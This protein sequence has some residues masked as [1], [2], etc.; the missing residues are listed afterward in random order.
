MKRRTA[1]DRISATTIGW[2]LALLP[3]LI[4]LFFDRGTITIFEPDKLALF[5]TLVL[6][7]IGWQSSLFVLRLQ[8]GPQRWPLALPAQVLLGVAV[9]ATLCSIAPRWSV[10]GSYERGQG[11]L[12]L[13]AFV[14]YAYLI[15]R[16]RA[17]YPLE[18]WI[19]KAV[20]LSS[21]AVV[22]YG[23]AQAV[24]LDPLDWQVEEGSFPVFS[25]L[26][27]SNY[28]AAFL[29]M[30]VPLTAGW[31]ATCQRRWQRWAMGL[32]LLG[33]GL[34]LLLTRSRGGWLAL[35]ATV[36]IVMTTWGMLRRAWRWVIA[37]VSLAVLG[38]ALLLLLNLA[39]RAEHPWA[40]W[41][42]LERLASLHE[43][44][45]GSTAAR[46]TI[47]RASLH[48]IRQ[49]PLLGHGP[50]TFAPAFA[51][52][53]PPELIYY[54]GRQTMVDRAHNEWLNLGVE[55]GALGLVAALWLQA[56]VW[57][58]GLRRLGD[59][60]RSNQ[61]AWQL[62]LLASLLA[63]SLLGLVSPPTAATLVL[64]WAL[65]SLV[66]P[67]PAAAPEEQRPGGETSGRQW[68]AAA[69]VLLTLAS[70][71]WLCLR[72]AIAEHTFARALR[73]GN[74]AMVAR[75]QR[76]IPGQDVYFHQ[77]GRLA[78]E[79]G[80][81]EGLAEAARQMAHATD[82]CPVQPL[83]WADLGTVYLMWSA[84]D[85]SRLAQAEAAFEAA[86]AIS[87]RQPLFL[88]GLG[89][90]YLAAGRHAQAEATLKRVVRLDATDGHAY[91]SLGDLY[92]AQERY[93][94]AALAYMYGRDL[95]P[96]GSA[97]LAGLG[98]AYRA[99]NRC[100]D[101]VV[102]LE[103]SLSMGPSGPL[104]FVA[105]ADCY[106]RLGDHDAAAEIVRQGLQLYPGNAE[107]EAVPP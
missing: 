16:Y 19:P 69:I 56:A 23:L 91:V 13:L 21:V 89:Q 101:A 50:G 62:C 68:A 106:A 37:G 99:L 83:Y 51:R 36:P 97:P 11:L 90:V 100:E 92:Y 32:L 22:L 2:S 93:E 67:P 29:V 71:G 102:E 48:L 59:L 10:W 25:T 41:P 35:G 45:T 105:L 26:G 14:A 31:L 85:P 6:L 80:G 47:W 8:P 73:R 7:L 38:I 63:N 28:L 55:M 86:L 40:E 104:T 17:T 75:A 107:L 52:V 81:A 18:E 74:M 78:A 77:G 54:Q 34:A 103:R 72:P 24:G 58:A 61:Q 1:P 94:E 64:S 3:A 43:T 39:A 88:R 95:W 9:L 76:W 27:R 12:V 42:P 87:P 15:Y 30:A 57:I 84:Q 46:V 33:Q 5:R 44:D 65:Y 4:A 70:V 96:D 49:R 82:L 20:V 98:R 79:L 53:Y 60:S 66:L